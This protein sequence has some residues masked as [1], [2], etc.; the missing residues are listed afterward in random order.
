MTR[1]RLG[2][3]GS[4]LARAQCQRVA[5]DLQTRVPGLAVELVLIET[6]GDAN[7]DVPL[8]PALGQAFFTKEI[9]AA[10]LEGRI[11]AAVHSCKDLATILPEGLRLVAIPPREDPRDVLVTRAGGLAQLPSGARVG[12]G[13]P[14]RRGFLAAARPDLALVD[15]RGNVPTRVAKVDEGVVDAAVLAAAGLLGLG[16]SDRIREW[17]EPAL[18]TPAAA[19]GAL[20]VQAREGDAATAA[21]VAVID[22]PDSHAE[23]A[24]ERACLRRLEAGCHAP[25]GALGRVAREAI[26]LDAALVGPDG[27]VR[28]RAEGPVGDAEGLGA[29][30][31]EDLLAQL[32]LESLRTADWAGPPPERLDV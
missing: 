18:M 12:T 32:G 1:L 20:A 4:R 9:E 21:L 13:S 11:D 25:V 16:M 29:R 30:V 24:A 23:V 27:V 2:T 14:R 22:H 26:S 17:F 8:T 6:F 3:R 19:Q 28:A 7:A 5:T 15:L 10:L 31:A